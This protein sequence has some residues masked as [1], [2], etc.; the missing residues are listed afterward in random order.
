MINT[1][2]LAAREGFTRTSRSLLHQLDA[3]GRAPRLGKRWLCRVRLRGADGQAKFGRRGVQRIRAVPARQRYRG[4]FELEPP[5]G[6]SDVGQEL[7]NANT[8]EED[9]RARLVPL[10][11]V[12][13]AAC[14]TSAVPTRSATEAPR[15]AT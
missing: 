2:G 3:Y 5:D 13:E 12:E 14:T 11:N 4:G 8:A 10:G 6:G 7:V 1:K 15:R 9:D